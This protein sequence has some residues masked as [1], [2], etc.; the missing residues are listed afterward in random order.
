MIKRVINLPNLLFIAAIV[1]SFVPAYFQLNSP[2]AY[3]VVLFLFEVRFVYKIIKNYNKKDLD[4]YAIIFSFFILWDLSS[5]VF[6]VIHYTILPPPENVF[7]IYTQDYTKMFNGF[8]HS[9]Y[10]II[11]GVGTGMGFGVLLGLLIGWYKRLRESISPIIGVV[12]AVPALVYAPYVVAVSPSFQTA[13][14][15]VIFLGIF[16][17][18]LINMISNV[19]NV[20][21]KL[22]DSAK[23]L[24][25][26]TRS[27]LF[28]V[29][30][31]D[32]AIPIL[33]SLRIRIATA[34]MIL[35]MAETIGS[36]VGL[37]YYVKKWSDFANYTKVFAG[38]ILIAVVV[39]GI[40]AL[41]ALFEKKALKWAA[42]QQ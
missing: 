14:I 4:L 1:V 29:L 30:L 41:I 16:W 8:L 26:S 27:M 35:T 18:T 3:I 20:D 10:L 39:T 5:K 36:S 42:S 23:S 37:G 38:I 11:M 13:S 7:Y 15:V 19:A 40:N 25:L 22:I 32:C 34:F 21:K 28:K 9:M 17:P 33:T 12:A 24:N 6:H 2:A 31:P